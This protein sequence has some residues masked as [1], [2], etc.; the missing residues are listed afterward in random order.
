MSR[1]TDDDRTLLFD[2]VHSPTPRIHTKPK[3]TSEAAGKISS[4]KIEELKGD[5]QV[6]CRFTGQESSKSHG[7]IVTTSNND[8]NSNSKEEAPV[9]GASTQSQG[10]SELYRIEGSFLLMLIVCLNIFFLDN[11]FSDSPSVPSSLL[12]WAGIHILPRRLWRGQGGMEG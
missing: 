9:S 11:S 12:D 8:Q 5:V 6:G 7:H 3:Q 2:K 4:E 10:G 1:L